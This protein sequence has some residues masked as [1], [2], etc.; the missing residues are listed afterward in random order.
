MRESG[1]GR[2]G[3]GFVLQDPGLGRAGPGFV[4]QDPG[5]GRAGPGFVLQDP[6]ARSGR[7]WVRFARIGARSG[8]CWV[9]FAFRG[10]DR[11]APSRRTFFPRGKAGTFHT[12]APTRII[13]AS[14]GTR[15]GSFGAI[16]GAVRPCWVRSRA[17]EARR[18]PRPSARSTAVGSF[19]SHPQRRRPSLP[20][21][22]LGRV[23][24]T[25]SGLVRRKA[26]GGRLSQNPFGLDSS[27]SLHPSAL[28]LKLL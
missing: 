7:S 13:V 12:I 17:V 8:W 6:G 20:S 16:R 19:S 22:R 2:A 24:A 3:P 28:P 18:A 1:P 21:D 26:E 4:L 15:L 14:F 27:F 5:P 11:A 23:R 9:R 25:L 10:S